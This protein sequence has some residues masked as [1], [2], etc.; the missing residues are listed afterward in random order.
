MIICA[1]AP[2]PLCVSPILTSWEYSLGTARRS[3]S[4]SVTMKGATIVI[5]DVKSEGPIEYGVREDEW[6]PHLPL[7]AGEHGLF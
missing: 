2:K 6:D 7:P 1:R 4:A 3:F 5:A